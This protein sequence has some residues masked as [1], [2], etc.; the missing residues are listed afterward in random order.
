VN[1]CADWDVPKCAEISLEICIGMTDIIQFGGV[2]YN[3]LPPFLN[4]FSQLL[5]DFFDFRANFHDDYDGGFESPSN[6]GP[7]II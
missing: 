7:W 5:A 1:F 4:F 6:T 3:L 2:E